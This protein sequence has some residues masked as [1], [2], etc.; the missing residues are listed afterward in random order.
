MQS[1]EESSEEFA[2]NTQSTTE[3]YQLKSINSKK[4]W[5]GD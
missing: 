4:R 2:S 3:N 1:F 5:L